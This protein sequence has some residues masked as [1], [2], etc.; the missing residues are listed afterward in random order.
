MV[1]ADGI[2]RLWKFSALEATTKRRLALKQQPWSLGDPCFIFAEHLGRMRVMPAV[3]VRTWDGQ[4]W[5]ISINLEELG[6]RLSDEGMA[7]RTKR[8]AR[9][10]ARG[11]IARRTSRLAAWLTCIP[12][13][14]R[15]PNFEIPT[16]LPALG[17]TVY[18]LDEEY[19][20]VLEVKVVTCG[21]SEF[22]WLAGYDSSPGNSEANVVRFQ[23]WWPQAAEAHAAARERYGKEY[24][25]MTQAELAGRIDA[26]TNKVLED[27][28]ARLRDPKWNH[29]FNEAMRRAYPAA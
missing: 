24:G 23:D 11:E 16:N 20:A 3:V 5:G 25:F 29:D 18:V 28:A 19:E 10:E 9:A 8:E 17:Q 6:A 2:L 22:S 12:L 1:A 26:Q 14:G 15:R 4:A 7:Y 27:A 21:L 13:A